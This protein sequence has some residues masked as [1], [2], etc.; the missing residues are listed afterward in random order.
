LADYKLF[1]DTLVIEL[2]S[3]TF[4]NE[5][6]KQLAKPKC[7]GISYLKVDRQHKSLWCFKFMGIF[8]YAYFVYTGIKLG[9]TDKRKIT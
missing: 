1:P 9:T 6:D 7:F 5:W 4:S 2:T 8:W 3:F